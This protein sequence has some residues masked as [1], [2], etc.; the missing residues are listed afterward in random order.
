MSIDE[1]LKIS[2]LVTIH[3]PLTPETK[4]LSNAKSI[5]RMK[6]DAVVLNMA[7]GSIVNEEDMYEALKSGKI[8]GYASDVMEEELVDEGLDTKF[9]SPL[10]ECDN[11]ISSP[12][13]GAQTVDASRDIGAY[14]IQKVKDALD[15]CAK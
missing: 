5:A 9:H 6:D 10:I 12:H 1:V 7:R 2:D 13:L 8:G 11:F 3:M 4:N 14:I 15:L